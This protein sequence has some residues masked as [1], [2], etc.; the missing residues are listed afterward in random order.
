MAKFVIEVPELH[1]SKREIDADSIGDAFRKVNAGEDYRE[2]GLDFDRSF[3]PDE[4]L[5]QGHPADDE[6]D[7]YRFD[8]ESVDPI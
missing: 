2:I 7:K 3:L 6:Q 4:Q 8:G 1:W 5:W